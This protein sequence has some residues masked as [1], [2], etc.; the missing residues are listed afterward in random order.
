MQDLNQLIQQVGAYITRNLPILQGELGSCRDFGLTSGNDLAEFRGLMEAFP[1]ADLQDF[2]GPIVQS[3][4]PILIEVSG[5]SF[6]GEDI[7]LAVAQ[8][9]LNARVHVYNPDVPNQGFPA[10][11]SRPRQSHF[12]QALDTKLDFDSG[13]VEGS[14]A[15][16]YQANGLGGRVQLHRA[17]LDLESVIPTYL[18]GTQPS[19]VIVYASHLPG[20]GEDNLYADLA[21][22]AG[23]T[24]RFNVILRPFL[25]KGEIRGLGDD[26][27]IG[28]MNRERHKVM[29]HQPRTE[30]PVS[31]GLE[32]TPLARMYTMMSLYYSL[33]IAKKAMPRTGRKTSSD[34]G[35]HAPVVYL[36]RELGNGLFRNPVSY[37]ST[38]KPRES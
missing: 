29:Q 17:S 16:L 9:N 26:P 34:L 32:S 4:S 14:A 18:D 10:F 38:I 31:T 37:V 13:D 21:S 35:S 11:L 25:L 36:E 5:S 8:R 2:L 28:L 30:H 24:P 12:F 27:V 15:R 22:G 33:L 7:G 6:Y 3:A 20:I 19:A 1:R 23:Y